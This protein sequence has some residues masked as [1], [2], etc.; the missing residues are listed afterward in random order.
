MADPM[1]LTDFY[2]T[3]LS[4][5]QEKAYQA[6]GKQQAETQGRNP[7]NDVYDYDMRGFWNA[8][9]G[10]PQFAENGHAGDTYKKPNHPTFSTFSQYHG[11]DGFEGGQWSQ[12]PGGSWNFAPGSGNFHFRNLNDLRDYFNRAE[13]GNNLD[14]SKIPMS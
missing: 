10:N 12:N 13:P 4:A 6:W 11:Q 9:Q 2:N 7:A 1:D 3:R 5:D 8:A 14:L